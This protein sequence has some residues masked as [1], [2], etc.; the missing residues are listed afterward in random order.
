MEGI[1]EKEVEVEP[2]MDITEP[3]EPAPGF[4]G[5]PG[6]MSKSKSWKV[7]KLSPVRVSNKASTEQ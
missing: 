3:I 1:F 2:P 7:P 5:M 4:L 6:A